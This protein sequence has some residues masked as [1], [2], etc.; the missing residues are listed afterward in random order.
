MSKKYKISHYMGL[1][2]Y[3]SFSWSSDFSSFFSTFSSVCSAD[4]SVFVPPSCSIDLDSSDC[5]FS[6]GKVVLFSTLRI[7]KINK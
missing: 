7:I 3:S 2:F 1:F 5:T 4:S 6:L